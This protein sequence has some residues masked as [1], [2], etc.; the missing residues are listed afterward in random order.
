MDR[1]PRYSLD[2]SNEVSACGDD[3][4]E[5]G[6]TEERADQEK[7][8]VEQ[9]D[10][11]ADDRELPILPLDGH[12]SAQDCKGL[13]VDHGEDEERV[14]GQIPGG[15]VLD[16]ADVCRSQRSSEDEVRTGHSDQAGNDQEDA[17]D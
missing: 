9:G 15:H 2:L 5:T 17:S 11:A 14:R 8:E 16:R 3:R 13:R 4:D 12:D 6:E 1:G 7:P 10:D